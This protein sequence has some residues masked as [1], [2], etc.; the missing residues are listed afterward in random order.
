M[1]SDFSEPGAWQLP[2]PRQLESNPLSDSS[3]HKPSLKIALASSPELV[4]Q[5]PMA[6]SED[7]LS[8]PPLTARRRRRWQDEMS[9]LQADIAATNAMIDCH[10]GSEKTELIGLR[11]KV[12]KMHGGKMSAE[13]CGS[14]DSDGQH[15]CDLGA[16]GQ[17]DDLLCH[18][19]PL[20]NQDETIPEMQ[21]LLQAFQKT[22]FSKEFQKETKIQTTSPGMQAS[23]PSDLA[24]RSPQS[25]EL[26]DVQHEIEAL[27]SSID[28]LD[29]VLSSLGSL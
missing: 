26:R 15:Q 1:M 9:A 18:W 14:P 19:A 23:W 2:S 10:F 11:T 29:D 22:S 4:S 25:G 16:I 8:Q 17:P 27:A 12:D 6:S 21:Q 24:R 5:L 3:I 13:I 7:L 28:Q 20:V